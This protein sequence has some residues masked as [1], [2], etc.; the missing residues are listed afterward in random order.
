MSLPVSPKTETIEEIMIS[1]EAKL[2]PKQ[3]STDNSCVEVDDNVSTEQLNEL[4][5][6]D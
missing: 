5:R 3:K 6:S 2:L 1:S 4:L